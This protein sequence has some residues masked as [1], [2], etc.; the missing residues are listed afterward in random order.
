MSELKY[1]YCASISFAIEI[2]EFIKRNYEKHSK[3]DS[4]VLKYVDALNMAIDAL[5]EKS[6][7]E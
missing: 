2:L 4:G 6:N 5:K 3:T 1:K 7:K